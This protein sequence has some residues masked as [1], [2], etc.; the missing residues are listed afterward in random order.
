M[1][2]FIRVVSLAAILL[3]LLVPAVAQE[4]ET[5]SG[6]PIIQGN[7]GDSI[8]SLNN[9][10][11]TGTDC[12]AVTQWLYPS[13]VGV[14]PELGA[15]AKG[16]WGGAMAYDWEVSEDSTVYTFQLRDDMFWNDGTPVTG[17]DYLFTYLAYASGETESAYGYI[18]EDFVD[19]SVSEDGYTVTVTFSSANCQNLSN[20]ALTVMPGHP[21]GWTA[22]MGADFD[23]S[24][25]IDHEYDTA[26]SVTGG[27][28]DFASM[29]SERVILT[30]NESYADGPVIPEGYVYVSI[31]DQ[32]VMAERFIAGELNIA[33]NPQNALRPEIRDNPSLQSV[34]YPGNSWDYMAFNLANPDNPQDGVELDADG[35]PVFDE[36][37]LPVIVEQESHPIF[38]DVRVRRAI[39]QA[40][41][42]DEIM[43][44]AVLG[45]GS[46]MASAIIPA[47]W[48]LHPDLAPTAYDPDA[49]V[50]L[51]AEA[52]WTP[53]DDGI[54]V[55]EDGDR[56][57]FELL[58]NEGNT[59]RGQ[60]GELIQDQLG[61]IGIEVDF[62]SIDF[63]QLLDVMDS[64]SFD[65]YI[66]GWRQGF[67]DDPDLTGLFTSDADVVGS[68]FNTPSYTNPEI[69]R[70]MKEALEVPGCA[71][72]DRAA[73]YH[74]IQEILQRDQPYVWLFAQDGFYAANAAVEGFDPRPSNLWWNAEQWTISQ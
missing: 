15:L 69:D 52:G 51:L 57:S 25:M 43:D 74:E 4:G 72:E 3:L 56:F 13:L 39:Q 54:L 41:N 73:I 9:I 30:A 55:N 29:D 7:A 37:D 53:G 20:A 24:V 2:R 58:T 31:P 66:L 68:G 45:E 16:T 32:T 33:D 47:S 14:D 10:R 46:I 40:L 23:F 63:N 50:A 19:V 17:W 60:I 18:V 27:I 1:S 6:G 12:R 36:N 5:G 34:N 65:A 67:P 70:L 11:C 8:G 61:A 21:F 49:A 22:D 28:F 48:A 35:N 71:T 59:R 44:K 38:G 42:L 62:V 64:Q 26:P